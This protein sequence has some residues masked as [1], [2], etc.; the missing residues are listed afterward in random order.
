[1]YGTTRVISDSNIPNGTKEVKTTF[2]PTI[3]GTIIQYGSVDSDGNPTFNL[4]TG[5]NFVVPHLYKFENNFG[6]A[7]KF[8]TRIGYKN[9]ELTLQGAF[10]SQIYIGESPT[11]ALVSNY[12]TIS[13]LSSLPAV[14]SSYDLN[15]DN[16]YF[17]LIPG[18]YN[19]TTSSLTAYNEYWKEYIETLYWEDNRKVTMDVKFDPIDYKDIRLNDNIYVNGTRYRINKINGFNLTQP[20]IATVE[21]LK[22]RNT[23]GIPAVPIVT[24]TP[25]P[26]PT[27]TPT[28]S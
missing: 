21:L 18:M 17:N 8:K 16:Q 6:K 24:I 23:E 5:S 7:Y 19:P 3:M 2:A 1:V 25:T 27:N 28:R 12:T 20:D 11:P 14:T 10:N 13:N 9:P 15:F 22:I 4:T 26:T